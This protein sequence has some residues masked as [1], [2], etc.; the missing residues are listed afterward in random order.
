MCYARWFSRRLVCSLSL[1][2][3]LSVV[4][5]SLVIGPVSANMASNPQRQDRKK[6]SGN[7]K[8]RKV[9]PRPPETGPPAFEAPNLDQAKRKNQAEVQ[10]PTPSPSTVRSKRKPFE[11]RNGKRVGDPGTT[12]GPRIGSSRTTEGNAQEVIASSRKSGSQSN[13]LHHGVNAAMPNRKAAMR[14]PAPVADDTFV[15]NFLS[16]T[17]VSYQSSDVIYWTDII[18]TAYPQGTDTMLMALREFGGTAFESA[19]YYNRGR[20]NHEYVYDLYQA[21][22]MRDPVNDQGGWNFWTSVCDAYGR[23]AVRAGFDQSTE[24]HDLVAAISLSGSATSAVSSPVSARLDPFNQ[25][26]DQLAARD[27]EWNLPL[28]NLKGR[29]GLDLGLGL[30]YS[31]MVWTRGGSYL[32]FDADSSGLSPGFRLGFASIQGPYF[33]AQVGKRIYLLITS[34]GRRVGLRQTSTTNVYESADSAY[35]QLIDYGSYLLLR[36]T[37]GTQMIYSSY[38]NG[39]QA[40]EI[41]DRNGNSIY[42]QNDW[43]GDIQYIY[44]TMNRVLYF[45]SDG[46]GNLLYIRQIWNGSWHYW[47]SFSWGSAHTMNVSGFTGASV[48]GTYTGEQI[49]VLRQVGLADG[50]YYTFDYTDAGQIYV[51]RNYRPDTAQRTYTAYDYD[52]STSDCPRIYQTRYW[53]QYW[54]GDYGVPSE[55]TTSFTVNGDGSHQVSVSGDPN[56]TVQRDYYGTGWQ[57]GLVTSSEVWSGGV[58]QKVTN[59]TYDHDGGSGDTFATNPR[60]R[61][62][63]T[64]DAIYNLRRAKMS[65]TSFGLV[66]DVYEFDN[67][68]STVLRRTHTDYNPNGNYTNL[69]IIGLPAAVYVC[70]GAQ[71]ETPC[72]YYSGSSLKSMTTY[73]YDESTPTYQGEPVR[74][75][76]NYG[77]GFNVR[78]NLTS[79]YRYNVDNLSQYTASSAQYNTNGSKISVSDALNHSSTISYADSFSDSTNHGTLAYPTTMTD[80]DNYS[81]YI[82]YN[83]DLG[84]KTRTQG[85]PPAGQPYGAVQSFLYDGAGRLERVTTDNTGAYVRYYYGPYYVQSFASVNNVADDSYSIQTFDGAGHVIGSAS[86]HP[87]S[88]GGYR[89][90]L[91]QY[92]IMGRVRMQSNPT[93][94]TGSWVP[95][96]DDGPGAYTGRQPVTWTNTVGVTVNGNS[97]TNTAGGWNTSAASSTQA[98]TSGDGY[99][100]TTIAETSTYRMI[101]LSYGDSNQDY[102]DIDFAIY[103]AYGGGLYVYESGTYKAALGSYTTGDVLRVSVES[104]VVKYRKNGTLLYTSNVSPS[105]PLLVDTSLYS[106]GSTLNTVIIS[107]APSNGGWVYTEQTYDWKGRPLVTTNQDGTQK[108][109]NYSVCGCAGSEVATITDEVGR[110]QKAYSDALGRRWKTEVLNWNG[111]SYSTITN[112]FNAR[113]QVTNVRQ[114]DSANSAYQDTVMTYDGYGRLYSKHVPEQN[115]GTATVYTY[116]ADDSTETVTDARGAT[117]TYTYNGNRRLVNSI[118][119]SAPGGIAATPTVS[120]TYDAAGNRTSMTD[121]IGN[122]S[123]S[124]DTLS[125]MTSETRFFSEL[126]HYYT[127]NY[128][129]NLTG[130]LASVSTPEWGRTVGY[131]Y[132]SMGQLNTVAG[133]GYV[134][135]YYSGYWPGWTWNTVYVTTFAS[136]IRRRAGGAVKQMTLG[137]GVQQSLSYDYR[138]QPWQNQMTNFAQSASAGTSYEY[139][140]DGKIQNAWRS[141]MATFDRSYSYDQA[142]RIATALTADEAHGGTTPGPYHELFGYDVWGNTKSLTKQIWGGTTTNDNPT[143]SNNRRQ[144][145]SYDA[146][147]FV[148]WNWDGSLGYTHEYDA[149]GKRTHFVPQV[150][151]VYGQHSVEMSDTFDGNGASNK[152]V[153]TRRYVDPE[154]YQMITSSTTGYYLHSTMLDGQVLAALDAQGN[155]TISYVYLAGMQLATEQVGGWPSGSLVKWQFNEP[156]TGTTGTTNIQGEYLSTTELDPLG[157]DI[158]SPPPPPDPLS[159]DPPVFSDPIKQT[160]YLI[161]GG[162]TADHQV[163]SWYTNMVNKDFD[164]H[165]A[166]VYWAHGFRDWAMEIVAN[167]PNVG[168]FYRELDK[169]GKIKSAGLR[170]GDKAASFLLGIDRQIQSGAL[171]EAGGSGEVVDYVIGGMQDP[172]KAGPYING[173]PTTIHGT[174]NSPNCFIQVDIYPGSHYEGRADLPNGASTMIING[175]QSYGLGFTVKGMAKGGVGT[176]ANIGGDAPNPQ[177]PNGTWRMEQYTQRYLVNDKG[178]ATLDPDMRRDM[179]YGIAMN[180]S[181]ENISWW[182]HPGATYNPSSRRQVFEVKLTRGN[183]HCEAVFHFEQSGTSITWGPGTFP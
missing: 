52:N 9:K 81:S 99:V 47:A 113:D 137:N 122:V 10:V 139:Y 63:D 133:S 172:K 100:E 32:Y 27:C 165:M 91:T 76:S 70:D 49:P 152:H 78:G 66:S 15:T 61:Q 19:A 90:Q 64:Y 169:N 7:D 35:L 138:Q 103:P 48:V 136:D 132:D 34:S 140:A 105:Y 85:P 29:A 116:R 20:S 167:N 129:Y 180:A 183:E 25:T 124:Y 26:G 102:S 150:G 94:I 160:Y 164:T 84:A 104:G 69:R 171:V 151:E 107:G 71:G 6:D 182:D 80:A 88:T 43:R 54:T 17:L 8:A 38:A 149:A 106:T 57:K 50:S 141:D 3:C 37:D 87:G 123:Y 4:L 18:R 168:V 143:I 145:W 142:G 115:V 155:R 162:P 159:Y 131:S 178:V 153:D 96:G 144:D 156:V 68:G 72:S 21:Y 16:Y 60:L 62:T 128:G 112:T 161:E 179:K 75:D 56:T 101:G 24:F 1:L 40:T 170:W 30:S 12:S 42:I 93:E 33:D 173:D 11:S 45:D 92:D 108:Y 55:I 135:G 134:T 119:Y 176:M 39:W 109:A 28:I 148:A 181:G 126:N 22:L 53:A 97:L 127:I 157:D 114:M 58:R 2:I 120:F 175:R 41:K 36:T 5:V 95:A 31:S 74:H 79:T 51:I 44:D 67:G 130:Q 121:A 174:G 23:A 86:S 125:R 111:T 46:N 110:Q 158:T 166:Q 65:Y 98:I 14:P 77:T 177:N 89:A 163:D 73:Q 118:S 154:T 83:Y 146:N 117:A 82:Q 147:G 13:K 59:M